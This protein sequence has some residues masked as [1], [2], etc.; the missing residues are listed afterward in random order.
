MITSKNKRIFDLILSKLNAN[1]GGITFSGNYM[2]KFNMSNVNNNFEIVSDTLNALEFTRVKVVPVVDVQSIQIPFVE[3][4]ERD[5]WEKEYYVAIEI[6][7]T[8]HAKTNETQYVFEESNAQY[9]AV[10]ETLETFQNDLTFI[11]DGYKYTFKVKEPTKVGVFVYN[12]IH[13]QI[14]ALT[15]NLTSLTSGFF[16]NETKAYFGLESDT[17]FGETAD[18]LLDVVELNE[19]VGKAVRA[20]S[21][22]NETEES[23]TADKRTW[24]ASMTINFNGDPAD[25]LIYK[26]KTAKYDLDTLYQIKITN[27]NLN[28]LLG[29]NL[30]YTYNVIV[31][32]V[33]ITYQNN[34][35]SKLTFKL[36][37]A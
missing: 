19:I 3:T 18:Y 17:S 8:Q 16:G 28:T 12:G 23:M 6:P 20:N 11:E 32:N 5:D 2:F 37:R 30:D 15:F 1:T 27:K 21:N 36:E 26:E 9:Q 35:V 25:I 24:E 14:L 7:Q 34:V 31:S 13:Y 29:E 33:N 4:N 10:L 22:V